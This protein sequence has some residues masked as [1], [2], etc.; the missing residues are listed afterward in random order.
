M[1]QDRVARGAALAV[2]AGM[3]TPGRAP[4]RTPDLDGPVPMT[5]EETIRTLLPKRLIAAAER[6]ARES[7]T[8][9]GPRPSNRNARTH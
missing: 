5:T 3:T 8:R 9:P 2:P 4:T 7:R 1:T 6:V